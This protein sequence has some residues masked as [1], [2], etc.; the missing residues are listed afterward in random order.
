MDKMGHGVERS[1]IVNV[2]HAMLVHLS[3]LTTIFLL[4]IYLYFY[5]ILYNSGHL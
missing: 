1:H 2:S 4:S 3:M 5:T